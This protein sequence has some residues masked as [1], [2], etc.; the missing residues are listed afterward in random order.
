VLAREDVEVHLHAPQTK[1]EHFWQCVC[2][3][4]VILKN[5]FVKLLSDWF[6]GNMV[7]RWIMSSAVIFATVVLWF[8]D[9]ILFSVRRSLSL[10]FGFWSLFLVADVIPW[11]VYAVITLETVALN[12]PNKVAILVTDAPAKCAPTICPLWKNLVSLPFCSTFKWTVTK[13]YL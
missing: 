3:Q 6:C 5:W 7:F 12:T 8:L 11:F 13:H 4:I 2:G 1:T 9:T 10:S